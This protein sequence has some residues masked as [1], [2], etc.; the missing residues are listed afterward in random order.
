MHKISIICVGREPPDWVAKGLHYYC[1]QMQ[2]KVQ[3][4]WL[5][6]K[7]INGANTEV[8]KKQEGQK[9]IDKLNKNTHLVALDCNGKQYSSAAFSD[10]LFGQMQQVQF[11]IGGANGLD[12]KVLQ[13]VDSVVSLSKATFPHQ[14]VKLL[15][16]EQIY[17]ACQIF[18]N[19]PYH[20]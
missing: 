8:V 13:L 5:F 19:H 11:I 15:L 1:K 6:V 9:I 20:K 16:V 7:P 2:N 18:H 14:L 17:R 3:L 4:V 12:G 10:W